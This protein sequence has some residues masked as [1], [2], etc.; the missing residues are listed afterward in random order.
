MI[1]RNTIDLLGELVKTSF[2]LRYQNSLLGFLWVLI[3]PYSTFLVLY[4]VWTKIANQQVENYSLYLLLGIIMYTYFSEMLVLGQMSLLERSSIILKVNF[5]RQ[6]VVLSSLISSVINLAI[7]MI[8]FFILFASK[9]LKFDILKF[10][11]FILIVIIFF[12]LTMA[13]S[14]FTSILTIKYRDLKNIVD[15]GLFLMYWATPIFY[16]SDNVISSD[17]TLLRQAIG[18]NP[19]G[20]LIN[21]A[22]ASFNIYSDIKI[23]YTIAFL[24]F[25]IILFYIG[26]SYFNKN[27]KKIAEFF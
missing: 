16:I 10:L 11:N 26:H 23:E 12:I 13:I 24:I 5:P 20:F 6:I 22:R 18:L 21:Q 9:D 4:L 3:K 19:I 25:S 8:F 17:Q 15:L 14:F 1:K 2:K 27:V 7:N